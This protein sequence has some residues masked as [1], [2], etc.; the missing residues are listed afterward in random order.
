MKGFFWDCLMPMIMSTIALVVIKL[1]WLK[2][3]GWFWVFLPILATIAAICMLVATLFIFVIVSNAI[4]DYHYKRMMY[5]QAKKHGLQCQTKDCP[6]HTKGF[7][8]K[9]S[10]ANFEKRREYYCACDKR[11]IYNKKEETKWTTR[12]ML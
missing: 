6:Y 5:L 4:N 11:T 7:C 3:I 1:I 12:L 9:Y 2:P 8:W 10:S